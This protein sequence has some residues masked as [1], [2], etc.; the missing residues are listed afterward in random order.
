M[1]L[2]ATA[3]MG[4]FAAGS[5]PAMAPTH[6]ALVVQDE[7]A[8]VIMAGDREA[9]AARSSPLDSTS[10]NVGGHP[11]KICYGRPSARGRTIFG[12]LLPYGKLWRTGANEPTM[13]HTAVALDVAGIRIEPGSYSLYTIPD[14]SEWTI[15]VNASTS[16]WGHERYYD[17]EVRAQEV[18]RA[19]LPSAPTEDYVETFTIRASEAE[20]G[21]TVVAL[22]WERTRL[23]IPFAEPQ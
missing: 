6:D 11:V 13:I 23:D 7:L 17:D 3:V 21:S 22:A 16:Q 14:S 4:M 8:C 2:I 18:G 1:R 20:D 5:G 15:I 9:A 10:F 19:T 12:G